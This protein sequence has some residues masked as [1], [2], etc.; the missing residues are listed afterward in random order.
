MRNNGGDGSYSMILID[1][2]LEKYKIS[3]DDIKEQDDNGTMYEFMD[4]KRFEY[5]QAEYKENERLVE[6]AAKSHGTAVHIR[7]T[8][9]KTMFEQ[10]GEILMDN[11]KDAKSFQIQFMAYRS[12]NAPI[13]LLLEV[14]G[15]SNNSTQSTKLI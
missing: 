6:D 10:V 12:Y 9:K 13:N 2:E 11:H 5:F 15:W 4:K 8:L 7:D 1:K 3:L 14:S